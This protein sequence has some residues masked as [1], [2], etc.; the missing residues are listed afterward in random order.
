MNPRWF[1][2][3]LDLETDSLLLVEKSEEDYREASFLDDRSLRPDRRQHLV[4]WTEVA[5]AV[6]AEARR[7]LHY[8][9]HIGHVGS[10]LISRLLGELPDVLAL[11]EPLIL[12]TLAERP[13]ELAPRLDT[14]TALLSR[15]FRPD[16]RAMVKA[17]SFVSEIAAE[18]VP[19]DSRALLLYARPERYVE[20]ILAGEN[21]RRESAV[22]RPARLARLGRRIADRDWAA[23]G[24]GEAI[25]LG[26]A[27]EMTSLMRASRALG[28]RAL[29]MDFDAFLA[30]PA[31]RLLEISRFFDLRLDAEE[32]EALAAHPLMR[33]YSKAPEYEYDADLRDQLLSRCRAEHSDQIARA[34]AWLAVAA[35][36]PEVAEA[37][38]IAS[39]SGASAAN[40]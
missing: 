34:Q 17:T 16:Q 8:I 7:D 39:T 6:P 20:T 21:S 2:H 15:T 11:R 36:V 24:E 26:W 4:P 19:A 12:R 3:R 18:L 33:R 5:G 38:R 27:A 32:A 31:A 40:R 14:V 1:P 23:T 35:S 30:A 22:T 25:A 9:F 37:L 13:A 28:E 29:M 10:T